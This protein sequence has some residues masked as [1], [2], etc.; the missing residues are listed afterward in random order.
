M[1]RCFI[2]PSTLRRAFTVHVVLITLAAAQS[3]S[4]QNARAPSTTSPSVA[5]HYAADEASECADEQTVRDLVLARL[6]RDPFVRGTS[7]DPSIPVFEIRVA[8][9]ARAFTATLGFSA[10]ES[11]GPRTLHGATCEEV[12]QGAAIVASVALQTWLERPRPNETPPVRGP[13]P[14]A[15]DDEDPLHAAGAPASPEPTQPPPNMR[16][17]VGA[18]IE[19]YLGIAPN[20]TLGGAL[21]V[22]A[23]FGLLT[24][25]LEGR[26]HS[27]LTSARLA[28]SDYGVVYPSGAAI[29]CVQDSTFGL[30]GCLGVSFGAFEAQSSDPADRKPRSTLASAIE[31]RVGARTP[32]G[33][34][35]LEAE[36]RLSVPLTRVSIDAGASSLWTMSP[37]AGGISFGVA[38][39]LS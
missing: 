3:V 4:G 18:T 29:G 36:L 10:S 6:G 13:L 14:Q 15:S 2:S 11:T 8:R 31:A 39:P 9:D 16:W 34:V 19:S 35:F 21:F 30:R 7:T 33:P 17:M 12:V 37:V 5:L 25:A 23:D 26:L 27:T 38:V 22:R 24:V 1:Q 28:S 20:P 32:L